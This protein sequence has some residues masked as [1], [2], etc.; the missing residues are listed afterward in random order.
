MFCINLRI[1]PFNSLREVHQSQ[2]VPAISIFLVF[3]AGLQDLHF[4]LQCAEGDSMFSDCIFSLP[5]PPL[6]LRQ[7]LLVSIHITPYKSHLK[8][9]L[10]ILV[11]NVVWQPVMA[12]MSAWN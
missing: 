5:Y 12:C 3:G 8:L 1:S 10:P 6:R 9:H 7:S 4:H 11:V 2:I